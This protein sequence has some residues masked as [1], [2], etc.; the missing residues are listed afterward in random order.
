MSKVPRKKTYFLL[1]P[2]E[3]LVKIGES[4]RPIA[5]MAV[6][7]TMNASP[8]VPLL[9]T[10]IDEGELHEKFAK[11]R[12]HGEWF[13]VEKPIIEYLESLEEFTAAD[14]LKTCIG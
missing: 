6:L 9:V 2:S 13:R 11:L 3:K 1:C 7:R 12:H 4:T 8:V 5:R 10:R 14:Q